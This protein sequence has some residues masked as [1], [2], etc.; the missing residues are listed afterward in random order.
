[1]IRSPTTRLLCMRLGTGQSGATLA[2]CIL[3][4]GSPRPQADMWSMDAVFSAT[5]CA[6]QYDLLPAL[7]PVGTRDTS[8]TR[9]IRVTRMFGL[10]S[11]IVVIAML[12]IVEKYL[13]FG[14]D[15]YLALLLAFY[16]AQLAFVPLVAGAFLSAARSGSQSPVA[17]VFA[18]GALVAGALVGI[19]ATVSAVVGGTGEMFLWGAIPACLL[20]SGAIYGLGWYVG[21]RGA[22]APRI[23][24]E[25]RD[26]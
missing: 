8:T 12:Y 22:A 25:T 20:V 10:V 11:Y 3:R 21:M 2:T 7:D 1:V 23:L 5:Q 9:K 26:Q 16:S 4:D 19:S 14:R 15:D 24:T 18:A 13:A 17:P 6:F